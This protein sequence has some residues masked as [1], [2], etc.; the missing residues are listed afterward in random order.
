MT[1]AESDIESALEP[2]I[3]RLLDGDADARDWSM[4]TGLMVSRPR[5]LEALRVVADVAAVCRRLQSATSAPAPMLFRWGD[6]EVREQIASGGTAQ[7]YRA[8]DPAL[9]IDVALKLH[10]DAPQ[11]PP[12]GRFLAEAR[13]LA[14]VRQRNVVGVYGAAVHDERAGL[15]CEWI[16]GCSLTQLLRERGRFAPAET[17]YIGIELCHALGALHAAGILH[18]DVK[19]ANVMR[20]RGGR[21]VL[22]DLGAGGAPQAVNTATTDYATPAYAAPE[23]MTGALRR[24]E[25]DLYALGRLLE[26]LLSGAPD[27][28]PPDTTAPALL[29]VLARATDGDAA[30]RYLDATQLRADLVAALAQIVDAREPPT[31][32]TRRAFLIGIGLVGI[33]LLL[34]LVAQRLLPGAWQTDVQLL[35]RSDAGTTPLANGA[36]LGPGER[37]VLELQS[38][39]P[40]HAYVLNEDA[41]GALHV[42]FPLHGLAQANPL[43]AQTRVRLPGRADKRDLSWEITGSGRREEFLIVLAVAPLPALEQRIAQMASV[44]IESV[45]R[46]VT[47]IHAEPPGDVVLLGAHLTALLTELGPDLAAPDR[48]RI[49]AYRFNDT[50]TDK[51]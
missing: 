23:I 14:R 29:R 41:D 3:G 42:L 46:G 4:A 16:D 6:F 19:P 15:W 1:P 7:V 49:Q 18:G 27:V 20:E 45:E 10:S 11:S 12:A 37:L 17:A 36:A 39:K 44:P 33:A 35:R 13:H 38:N 48:V 40:L 43:P 21:I 30:K 51:R 8:Y 31:R 32:S 9:G 5:E 25:H 28:K 26:T 24:P 50:P 22:L 47:K 2:A 34:A